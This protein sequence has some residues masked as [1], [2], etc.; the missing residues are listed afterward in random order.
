MVPKK[1]VKRKIKEKRRKSIVVCV[2]GTPGTGKTTLSK[3]ICRKFG[4]KYVDLN[5]ILKK[6]A[7]LGYDKKRDSYIIDEEKVS[8]EVEKILKKENEKSKR[9]V[10]FDSH[11]SHFIK[12]KLV[13]LCI[14]CT[15]KLKELK[16]R[17]QGRGYKKEK[18]KENLEAEIFQVCEE[19]AR[20]IGHHV[21]I[22]DCSNGINEEGIK[23]IL[24]GADKF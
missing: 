8:R 23:D 2:S 13:D 10:V 6:T 19:E 12:P 17:L 24:K 18:V 9:G 4:L 1:E 22:V 21:R 11:L 20:R 14:I 7:S 15:C 5:N 16:R 3:L